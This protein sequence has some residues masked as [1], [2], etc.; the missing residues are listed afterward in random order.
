M[1]I[2][3]EITTIFFDIDNTLLN[4]TGAEIRGIAEVQRKYFPTIDPKKF[5]ITWKEESKRFWEEFEKGKISFTDQRVKRIQAIW[6]RFGKVT[7]IADADR[8]FAEYL[9]AYEQSWEAF[10]AVVETLT[11]LQQRGI[12][13]GILSNGGKKQQ[14]Q[15]LKKLNIY[16]FID[17]QLLIVSEEAGYSKPDQ[18]IFQFAQDKVGKTGDEILFV[19]DNLMVDII[20]AKSFG[21]KAVLID[22][23]DKYPNAE[24]IEELSHI[25]KVF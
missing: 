7:T 25:L 5:E 13:I 22:Y 9:A 8:L 10:P 2:L 20:S 18:R 1:K 11:S 23:F 17:P 15:K 12:I 16:H 14:I 19:G 4:H 6:Q 3:K 24:S 21:W